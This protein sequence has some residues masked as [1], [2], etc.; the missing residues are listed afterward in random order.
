MCSTGKRERLPEVCGWKDEGGKV[1][2]EKVEDETVEGWKGGR[3]KGRK[4][5]STADPLTPFF[6]LRTRVTFATS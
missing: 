4:V 2:G 5:A 6:L 1:E 3:W